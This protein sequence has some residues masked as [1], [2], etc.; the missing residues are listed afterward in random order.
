[1]KQAENT[2]L[3]KFKE[4]L[5]LKGHTSK[6]AESFGNTAGRF[7]QWLEEQNIEA[8]NVSYNDVLAYINHCRSRGNKARTLQVITGVLKHF[9]NHLQDTEQVTENPAYN[10]AIKGIKR[11]TL[12]E[13]LTPE[14]LETIYKSYSTEIKH[15]PNKKIPPQRNNELARK[16][17]KSFWD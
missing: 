13:I 2:Y 11:K 15:E 9:Y 1:M 14:E 4:W 10:V 8:E 6:T 5:L 12:H 7:L 16:K 17:T 3:E